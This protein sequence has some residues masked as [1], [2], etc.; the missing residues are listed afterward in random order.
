M[1]NQL[2]KSATSENS[3]TLHKEQKN[4]LI[5]YAT[6]SD[7]ANLVSSYENKPKL[8]DTDFGSIIDVLARWRFMAG[9]T[10]HNQDEDDI[11]N[12]LGLIATFIKN[13][14]SK[15]TLDEV[16]LSINL[17]LT[18]K[19]DV[20]VRTFNVF[21]PMYVSR[22]LNGYIEYKRKMYNDLSYR[23]EIKESN[24][25]SHVP[26]P[27]EK[28]QS[29]K[30]T[31]VY[32]Y[33]QYKTNGVINDAFNT[34]YNYFRRTKRLNP[35]KATID[36]AVVYGKELAKRD[37]RD[38]YGFNSKEKYDIGL[39]EKRYARNY[40]VQ[41]FFDKINIEELTLSINLSEFE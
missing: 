33:Q 23:K 22:I 20:D 27:E 15:L 14:Y 13:N 26:T 40:C 39:I 7:E 9:I 30:D 25:L 21:S 24:A 3:L 5:N 12:E 32:F 28:M 18:D 10:T 34:L 35:D 37:E 1:E 16:S 36:E 6:N 19:L 17:S 29:M 31:I 4:S 11:A 38:I 41:K 2:Q 8:R